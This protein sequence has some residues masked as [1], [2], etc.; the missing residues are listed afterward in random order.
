MAHD[1]VVKLYRIQFSIVPTLHV[2][3]LALYFP[4]VKYFLKI[5]ESLVNNI[6]DNELCKNV[7][8]RLI[9]LSM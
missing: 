8:Q 6:P 9:A 2:H 7:E 1:V 3:S 4:R 5:Y